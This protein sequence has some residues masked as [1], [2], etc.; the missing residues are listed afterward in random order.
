[1]LI[2][3]PRHLSPGPATRRCPLL[4][5][6]DTI[7]LRECQLPTLTGLVAMPDHSPSRCSREIPLRAVIL[8]AR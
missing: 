8:G 2:Q 4:G 1:M 5:A 7:T 3:A 6:V